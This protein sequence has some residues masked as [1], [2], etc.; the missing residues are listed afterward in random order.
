MQSVLALLQ[1][2]VLPEGPVPEPALQNCRN[3]RRQELSQW[4]ILPQTMMAFECR[5]T[6][7]IRDWRCHCRKPNAVFARLDMQNTLWTVANGDEN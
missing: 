2:K 3:Q 1:F 5:T 6:D 7:P 4:P